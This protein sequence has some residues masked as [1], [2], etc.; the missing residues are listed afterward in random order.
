MEEKDSLSEIHFALLDLEHVGFD[1]FLHNEADSLYG[2]RLPET[3]DTIDGLV[4]ERE[5]M[6]AM[7][8]PGKD[9]REKLTSTAGFQKGS[10]R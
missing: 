6:S 10:M 7:S 1:R 3:V 5:A 9:Q 2:H 8:E 4:L